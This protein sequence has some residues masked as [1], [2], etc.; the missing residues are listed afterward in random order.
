[1]SSPL[2]S[3][4]TP[5]H[6]AERYLAASID[7]ALAQTLDDLEVIVI[8]DG[9]TDGS[10]AIADAYAQAHPRVRV[11]HQGNSG[12]CLARN[13]A[14]A[15]ARGRYLAML[16]ADDVWLPQHLARCVELLERDH[17]VGMVHANIERIDADGKAL[18]VPARF[19]RGR[20]QD[21]FATLYLRHEHV[22]CPTV[23]VRRELVEQLGAFDE[24]FNRVGCEDRDLWLR[25]AACSRLVYL[26][27]VHA[28]YRL[29]SGNFSANLDKM[30]RARL[31]LIEKCSATARG[32]AL[33]RSA[34]AAVHSGIGDELLNAGRR[35]SAFGAYANALARQ[36]SLRA[37]K[38]MARALLRPLPR[39]AHGAP[40]A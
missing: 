10:A 14:I 33:R 8:D 9:A 21:A 40:H 4:V 35:F 13:A 23:V 12:L 7:S 15:I 16:D 34:L 17:E 5:V 38:S 30:H 29:H 1:M 26:D 39:M 25:V 31:L 18:H 11:V 32:A 3:V 28:R 37:L 22:S 19:W 24:R 2:V 27:E 6:N 20:E 36:P